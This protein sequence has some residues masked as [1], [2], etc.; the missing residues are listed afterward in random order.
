M[1]V[2]L[3]YSTQQYVF[4]STF[5]LTCVTLPIKFN[6]YI[7]RAVLCR[8]VKKCL[9]VKTRTEFQTSH[10]KTCRP[11]KLL[12][13]RWPTKTQQHPLDRPWI[14]KQLLPSGPR[15]ARTERLTCSERRWRLVAD[16]QESLG[17]RTRPVGPRYIGCEALCQHKPQTSLW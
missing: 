8:Q 12:N 14:P 13:I 9:N 2:T 6:I 10:I 11:A 17:V 5:Q 15:G 16:V 7:S 4:P 3:L 1:S